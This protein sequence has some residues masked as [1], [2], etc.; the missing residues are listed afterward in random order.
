M[1]KYLQTIRK[2][3]MLMENNIFT[4]QIRTVMEEYLDEKRGSLL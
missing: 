1:L 4:N 3:L 2:G